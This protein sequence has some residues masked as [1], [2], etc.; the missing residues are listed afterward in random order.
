M[1]RKLL[2]ISALAVS[3]T[4][5]FTAFMCTDLNGI[6]QD[7]PVEAYSQYVE[8]E[9]GTREWGGIEITGGG[10]VSG[11]VTGKDVMY[12]RTDVGGAYKYNYDTQKWEQLF[13]FISETDRGMLSVE[14]ITIDPTDDDTV[15]FL[16]G[17]AY[18]SDAR[19]SIYKTTDGGKTLTE[20]DVTD[21]IRVMGNG[22]GR[23]FGERIVVDPE[24]T[25]VLYC[26]GRTNGMIKSTDGGLTWE[27]V[28]GFDDLNLFTGTTKWPTWTDYIAKIVD[29][30][31]TAY[32]STNGVSS[33]TISD[34]KLFVGVSVK[35]KTNIYVSDDNGDTFTPLSDDLPTDTYPS[36]F[37]VDADG[38]VL[39]TYAG[40]LAFSG[41]GGCYRYNIKDGSVDNITPLTKVENNVYASP[42]NDG[43][44]ST[45][46]GNSFGAVFSDPND[47]NKLVAT[48]C[49]LW[50]GQMWH[51]D[52]WDNDAV[53]YGDITYRSTDGGKTWEQLAPGATK[54]WN[55]PLSA[56]YLQTGGVSWVE[57]KAIHW[58]G[59]MVIDPRNPDKVWVTSGN[60]IFTCDNIWDELPQYSFHADG[61]EEVVALDMTSVKGGN[62]YSAIGD[63]DGFIHY[64]PTESKQYTPN[65]GSTSAIAYCPANPKVMVRIPEGDNGA[66][67][68][69]M[70][71]GDTWTQLDSTSGRGGKATITQ[72]D[73]DTYRIMCSVTGGATY[74][75]DFG[76]T[77]NSVSVSGMYYNCKPY[78]F[79]DLENPQYVYMYGY[80]QPANQWDT[81][82]AAYKLYV[83]SDYG[84]TFSAPTDICTYD[85]CDAATRIAYI[86]EGDLVLAGGWYGLYHVTE[87]GKK[88]ESLNVFYC[89][90]VGYGAPKDENSPNTL[91]IWGRP[92]EDDAEGIYASTDLGQSWFRVNDD[93]H[94]FGGTGNGNFIVG[95]MNTYGTFYMSTV[96]AG[97]IYSQ[98]KDGDTPTPP[99]TTTTTTTSTTTTAKENY[100]LDGTV[101]ETKGN[102]ITIKLEDDT[103]VTVNLDNLKFTDTLNP[104][105]EVTLTFDGSTDKVISIAKKGD[106]TTVTTTGTTDETTTDTTIDPNVKTLLGD[107][108]CDG[109]VKSNDLLLLKKYLL[110]L[111]DLS[112]QSFKNSDI[113]GDGSVKSN[114]LL[115]L[116]KY[117]LGLID[118]L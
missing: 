1:S 82:P 100:T 39:I 92:T 4:M 84:K 74:T 67:Y 27:L 116:K 70:D 41:S 85:Y 117:L 56:D 28:K 3:V 112:E 36:R 83:S 111:D 5:V 26:G 58:T 64:S 61:I 109:F 7:N 59:C 114:D 52:D 113:N 21:L 16:C 118:E 76:K 115:T 94:Q 19:T 50:S 68:Y 22:D 13:G 107:V 98:L 40:A 108:N 72:L 20:V 63:Y 49:G 88:S 31:D 110:G 77:W 95:D 47:S 65:I 34:G 33:L 9:E 54:Y 62:V 69:S 8:T 43:T 71:G 29:A 10:F 11:I 93:E 55:G 45:T 97:I 38:N 15:Y 80:S 44:T 30:D 46:L 12:A 2:K 99:V 103:E 86:G 89:K 14:A 66:G 105:D 60:G 51:A 25:D 17:C 91:Y 24:N 6:T 75:D 18:F 57:G 102:D 48:T 73:D 78:V 35:G 104:D 23:H 87:Y 37:N 96:G 106:V 42:Y 90:T 101:T 79:T 53:C 32:N 81:T